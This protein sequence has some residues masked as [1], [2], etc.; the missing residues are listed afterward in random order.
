MEDE[1]VTLLVP[2][3]Q[4]AE[5]L[6]FDLFSFQAGMLGSLEDGHSIAPFKVIIGLVFSLGLLSYAISDFSIEPL[7][8]FVSYLD[9]LAIFEN[10]LR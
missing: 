5:L 3:L 4:G 7:L 10:A 8:Y 1:D 9:D 6:D 2:Y